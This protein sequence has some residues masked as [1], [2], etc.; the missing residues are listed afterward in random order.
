MGTHTMKAKR[1]TEPNTPAPKPRSIVTITP[2]N[3]QGRRGKALCKTVYA[4]HQ[5]IYDTVTHRW[6]CAPDQPRKRRRSDS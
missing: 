4:P 6:P 5:D 1:R 3:D 2:V